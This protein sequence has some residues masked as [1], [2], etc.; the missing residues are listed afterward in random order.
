MLAKRIIIWTFFYLPL[1]LALIL[2][3][4]LPHPIPDRM[5]N[6]FASGYVLTELTSLLIN[7][8]SQIIVFTLLLNS[9]HLL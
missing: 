5:L 8:R 7:E 4:L 1:S 6:S 3:S 2:L 9:S